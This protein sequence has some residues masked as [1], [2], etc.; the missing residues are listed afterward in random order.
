[1]ETEEETGWMFCPSCQKLHGVTENS[2]V[3]W[4]TPFGSKMV[5][6]TCSEVCAAELEQLRVDGLLL[7]SEVRAYAE[8]KAQK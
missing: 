1:M 7:T 4:N 3:H 8:R 2:T 6:W 5:A